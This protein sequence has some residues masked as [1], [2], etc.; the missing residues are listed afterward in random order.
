MGR[1]LAGVVS[2]A[3]VAGCLG[4][5]TAA[6]EPSAATTPIT[7]HQLFNGFLADNM[8]ECSIWAIATENALR[9]QGLEHVTSSCSGWSV[10]LVYGWVVGKVEAS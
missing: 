6:A 5:G 4:M 1:R 7:F 3:L 2:A 8:K 10:P 9:S